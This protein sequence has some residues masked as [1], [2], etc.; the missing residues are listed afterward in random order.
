MY[1]KSSCLLYY[2]CTEMMLDEKR[3]TIKRMKDKRIEKQTFSK[4]KTKRARLSQSNSI[5]MKIRK[6]DYRFHLI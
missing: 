1:E 5:V 3:K 4:K 2:F 6:L